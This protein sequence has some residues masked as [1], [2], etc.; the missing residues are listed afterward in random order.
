MKLL[1]Y[2][3]YRLAFKNQIGK[4]DVPLSGFRGKKKLK[5]NAEG[6]KSTMPSDLPVNGFGR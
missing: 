3:L 4:G 6:L 1:F 5:A 2:F